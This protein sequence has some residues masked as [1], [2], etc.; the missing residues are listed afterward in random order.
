MSEESDQGETSQA[1]C[2]ITFTVVGHEQWST[3][4]CCTVDWYFL[5]YFSLSTAQFI[6]LD[7]CVLFMF[8]YTSSYLRSLLLRTDGPSILVWLYSIL[9]TRL[10]S[11]LYSI[12]STCVA[13][14]VSLAWLWRK[15]FDAACNV[16]VTALSLL[17]THVPARVGILLF[18]FMLW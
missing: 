3:L 1:I 14:R 12:S 9:W 6:M 4:M 5:G 13:F 18:W 17:T 10:F 7:D 15:K 11:F 2:Q 16:L 8:L